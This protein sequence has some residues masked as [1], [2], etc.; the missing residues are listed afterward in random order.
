LFFYPLYSDYTIQS[1]YTTGTWLW[2]FSVAWVMHYIANKPFNKEV[3][4][5]VNGSSM[6]AY[7][8]HYLFIIL[9]AVLLIRPYKIPFVWALLLEVVLVNATIILTYLLFD[10]LY[11]LCFP[12]K[13]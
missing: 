8:S 3:Y 12:R 9:F 6:Y 5:I 2:I 13:E 4:R 7:L 11:H 10:W 1:L